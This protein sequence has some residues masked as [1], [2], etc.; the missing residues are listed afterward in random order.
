MENINLL[1]AITN[2]T[3]KTFSIPVLFKNS[4][5]SEDSI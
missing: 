3:E 2:L 4:K 5:F 1:T